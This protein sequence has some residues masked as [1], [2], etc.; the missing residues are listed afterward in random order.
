MAKLTAETIKGLRHCKT[1]QELKENPLIMDMVETL[2]AQQEL[3]ESLSFTTIDVID[4][5]GKG[6]IIYVANTIDAVDHPLYGKIPAGTPAATTS[7]KAT[8]GII[9]ITL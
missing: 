5:P 9:T 8:E 4:Q 3:I 7:A 6:P 1:I 2:E